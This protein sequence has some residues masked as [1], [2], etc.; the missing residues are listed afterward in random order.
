M[1]F[2]NFRSKREIC[3]TP[4]NPEDAWKV[5]I[6]VSYI[7]IHKGFLRGAEIK[8]LTYLTT[9]FKCVYLATIGV[10]FIKR[11]II[12]NLNNIFKLC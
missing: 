8:L 3:R 4:L 6:F 11:E 1:F 12:C 5:I 7:G 10:D 2:V 9:F